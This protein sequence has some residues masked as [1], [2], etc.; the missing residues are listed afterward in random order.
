LLV[1]EQAGGVVASLD[2]DQAVVV[3][4]VVGHQG[5]RRRYGVVV[6]TTYTKGFAGFARFTTMSRVGSG[7]FCL[8]VR[9]QYGPGPSK[10]QP[11]TFW[12][13]GLMAISSFFS[14]DEL[15]PMVYRNLSRPASVVRKRA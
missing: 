1:A 8:W 7:F 15:V 10:T 11:T 13:R 5:A 9:P 2:G 3:A 6:D 4:A 14:S 12:L